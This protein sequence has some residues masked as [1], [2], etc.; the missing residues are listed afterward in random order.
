MDSHPQYNTY[1]V[2]QVFQDFKGRRAGLIKAL[3]TD[4]EDFYNQ[5]DPDKENLCLYGF[6]NEEWKLNLPA[7]AIP[8]ELPE[9][10]L[11][12]NFA[13]SGMQKT[14]WL[15]LVAAHSDSWLVGVASYYGAQY[16]FNKSDRERLFSMIN[17]LPTILEIVT[18]A[19]KKQVE[20]SSVS[21]HSGSKSKSNSIAQ[22]PDP[23]FK[24]TKAKPNVVEEEMDDDENILCNCVNVTP[25]IAEEINKY[26]CPY[27][28]LQFGP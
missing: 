1:T 21:N 2:E 26:E 9:P 7:E 14:D 13:R 17:E 4:V 12:I 25:S 16:G 23:H 19:A 10:S 28:M 3:T 22:A 20:K 24:E 11:G 27:C 6:P 5:C 18:D 8:S 15:S